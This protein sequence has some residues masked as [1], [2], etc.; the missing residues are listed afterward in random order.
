MITT[1]VNIPFAG[2]GMGGRIV[3]IRPIKG[4]KIMWTPKLE[5]AFNRQLNLELYSS[6]L[7]LSMAA[8][9]EAEDLKGMAHWM[10]LQVDEEKSHAMRIFNFIND[11]N[12]RVKLTQID[13]PKTEWKSPVEAFEDSYAHEQKVTQALND[14]FGLAAAERDGATHDRLEWFVREQVEE[15]STVKLIISQLKLAGPGVGVYLIDQ[16]LG[17]RVAE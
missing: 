17:K 16:E 4:V 2:G 15:E 8:Y 12:G 13:A 11:R 10:Q 3:A 7:Y 6:Y 5:E 1:I 14:L 9:F